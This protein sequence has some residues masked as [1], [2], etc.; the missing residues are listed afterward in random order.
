MK[1]LSKE[2]FIAK[3]KVVHG[4]K[5]DY[6]KV[7]YVNNST[8]VCIVCPIHG[9]FWQTPKNHLQGKGC[10][11]CRFEDTGNRCRYNT[12]DFIK[13][14]KRVHGDKYDY[15]LVEYT[16]AQ[17]LIDIVCRK[18][19]VFKQTPNNHISGCGC[20]KCARENCVKH[21]MSNSKIY[22]V[23]S[24]MLSRCENPNSYKYYNYGGRGVKVC[25]EWKDFNVF[26]K[27]AINNG[28]EEG[29]TIERIDVNGDY[30]PE[31][32]TWIPM[33]EQGFNKR[34]TRFIEMRG[35]KIPISLINYK[36]GIK[37][38]R[39]NYYLDRYGNSSAV[40]FLLDNFAKELILVGLKNN[41]EN[42]E[43]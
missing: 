19:G 21:C 23:H 10:I 20:P 22:K 38:G 34:N 43:K 35:R 12:E 9:E 5:Y 37:R 41:E 40:D 31:N 3:S 2:Q 14:A 13:S 26:Y 28:Y 24:G 42:E 1:K 15:S 17:T 16:D 25:D 39:I 29:L 27:W 30:C 33:R 32:C 7:E 11:K 36:L 18:H 8:K 4:D 6:S